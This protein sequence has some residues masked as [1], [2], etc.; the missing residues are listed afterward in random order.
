MKKKREKVR[1]FRFDPARFEIFSRN[2]KGAGRRHWPAPLKKG[3][4]L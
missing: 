1:A 3:P 4:R 2:F